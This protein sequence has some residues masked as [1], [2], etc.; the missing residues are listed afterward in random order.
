[1]TETSDSIKPWVRSL[2]I[3]LPFLVI[4]GLFQMVGYIFLGLDPT[5]FQLQESPVQETV[6]ALFTLGAT[7]VTVGIFRRF[8]DQ[9]SFQ[10]M[11]FTRTYIEGNLLPAL[12]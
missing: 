6:G 11:G 10:S 8:I 2:L 4:V 9:E 7:I 1:M 5:N 12:D 3:L